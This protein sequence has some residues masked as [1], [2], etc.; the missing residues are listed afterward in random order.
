MARIEYIPEKGD[1]VWIDFNPQ[2][3]KEF[4]KRR[5][6]LVLSDKAYNKFGLIII[7]PFTSKI[8]G[9][10]F[11]VKTIFNGKEGCVIADHVKSYDYK[12]RN[13]SFIGK[14]ETSLVFEVVKVINKL[15][16]PTSLL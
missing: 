11:E 4:A 8:K 1:V 10:P 3:G 5:P 12:E 14:A 2:K 9:Y 6:A 7:C 15:I 13:A 16:D